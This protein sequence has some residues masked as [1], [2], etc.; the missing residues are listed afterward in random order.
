[1]PEINDPTPVEN[2]TSRRYKEAPNN[3]TIDGVNLGI[4][5]MFGINPID[6]TP[7]LRKRMS[8]IQSWSTRD[9]EDKTDNML[10]ITRLSRQFG[11]NATGEALLSK[12]YF[13]VGLDN[14]FNK[15]KWSLK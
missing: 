5:K 11:A 4:Y 6:T 12:L 10:K 1:M 3:V 14:M 7:D 8:A 2:I 9:T 13:K 15:K